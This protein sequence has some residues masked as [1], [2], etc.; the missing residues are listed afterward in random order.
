MAFSIERT[1]VREFMASEVVRYL[2]W[3]GGDQLKVGE[4][5]WL[6]ARD[7]ARLKAGGGFDLKTFQR[8]Q[9]LD[10]GPDGSGATGA[11]AGD[12]PRALSRRW[13]CLEGRC[14]RRG[15]GCAGRP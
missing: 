10:L 8:S 4:Q 9:A 6:E 3:A 12:R 2:G 15:G 13:C 11:R 5:S 7:G 14:R 1:G